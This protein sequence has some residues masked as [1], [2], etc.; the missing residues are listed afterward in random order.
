VLPAPA[1][2]HVEDPHEPLRGTK[3][4]VLVLLG[5]GR[6]R[7]PVRHRAGVAGGSAGSR[8][9]GHGEGVPPTP[10]LETPRPAAPRRAPPRPAAPPCDFC[11]IFVR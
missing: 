8:R 9:A 6:S 4:P 2:V 3:E 10:S 5:D 7:M 1:G 11:A